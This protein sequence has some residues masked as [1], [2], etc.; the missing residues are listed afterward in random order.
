MTTIDDPHGNVVAHYQVGVDGR[1]VDVPVVAWRV[2]LEPSYFE[3]APLVAI[4]G[5]LLEA[6]D[7]DG[8]R[9][10]SND[11]Q[12]ADEAALQTLGLSAD[13]VEAARQRRRQARQWQRLG[14]LVGALPRAE[15]VP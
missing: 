12:G 5:A 1:P 2:S 4:R 15:P 9:G 3:M 13:Q 10:L 7:L 6:R 8:Y 11:D 14:E